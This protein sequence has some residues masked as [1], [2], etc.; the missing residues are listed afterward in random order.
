[1]KGAA[2]CLLVPLLAVLASRSGS[3]SVP[4]APSVPTEPPK[5]RAA[6]KTVTLKALHR[7]E[8]LVDVLPVGTLG[9][10]DMAGLFPLVGLA[11]ADVVDYY[12]ARAQRN[13]HDVTRVKLEANVLVAR[14][15]Q[16]E[17]ETAFAGLGSIWLVSAREIGKF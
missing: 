5:P 8:L 9:I 6:A 2:L 15:W 16:L 13:G 7:Y 1:M 17:R 12:P 10:A 4:S 3:G 14:S 11:G